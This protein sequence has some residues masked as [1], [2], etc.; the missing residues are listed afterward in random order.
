MAIRLSFSGLLVQRQISKKVTLAANST[1]MAR[2][3]LPPPAHALPP[4]STS[5]HLRV[6]AGFE[7]L[8]AAGRS[9]YG[10]PETYTTSRSI[11]PGAG[12]AADQDQTSSGTGSKMLSS[13]PGFDCGKP[14]I[15]ALAWRLRWKCAA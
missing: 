7:L 6:Q 15:Y 13:L 14:R 5:G 8:F 10:Q 2:K 3:A 11:G 9:I 4:C 12:G 1:A